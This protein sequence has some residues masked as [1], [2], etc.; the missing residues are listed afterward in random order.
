MV[1]AQ[2]RRRPYPKAADCGLFRNSVV[3]A[4]V[5]KEGLALEQ[6]ESVC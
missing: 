5:R 6:C 2:D 4:V 1:S 3:V